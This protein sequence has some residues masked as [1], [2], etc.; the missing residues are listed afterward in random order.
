MTVEVD[1][2]GAPLQGG[3]GRALRFTRGKGPPAEAFWSLTVYD[4]RGAPV[5]GK[6]GRSQ[7]T[8]R[9]KFQYGRDGSLD[10]LLQV[11]WPKGRE[12]NW[13]QVPP[14]RYALV[15]RLHG[16]R[17]KSPSALDGSWKPPAIG[18]AR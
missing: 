7:L 2:G 11:D 12:S 8:S 15:L 13:L 14:G 18:P 4:E 10:L 17:E 3:T 16:P 5:V 9:S 6:L 1:G